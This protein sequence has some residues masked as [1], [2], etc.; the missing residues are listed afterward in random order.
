M[1]FQRVLY[2]LSGPHWSLAM[3]MDEYDDDDDD[4]H[5]GDNFGQ[6]TTTVTTSGK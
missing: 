4:D 2:V 1:T 5:D 3:V 6:T